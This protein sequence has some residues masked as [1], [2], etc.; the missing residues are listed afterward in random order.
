MLF[1]CCGVGSLIFVLF[2]FVFLGWILS[3]WG[4]VCGGMFEICF[5]LGLFACGGDFFILCCCLGLLL[6]GVDYLF[7]IEEW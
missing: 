3:W 2:L 4:G 6:S 7:L 1:G 5:V